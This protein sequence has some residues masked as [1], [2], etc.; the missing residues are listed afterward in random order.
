MLSGAHSASTRLPMQPPVERLAFLDGL[1]GWAALAVLLYYVFA[2]GFPPN[3]FAK[4]ELSKIVL[5]NGPYAVKLFFAISGVSLSLPYFA[6]PTAQT[7]VRLASGRYFRLAIPVFALCFLVQIAMLAGWPVPVDERPAVFREILNFD[8]TWGHLLGFGLFDVFLQYDKTQTYAGPLW[9]MQIEFTGSLFVLLLLFLLPSRRLRIG[10]CALL[11][12]ILS[13]IGSDMAFFVI[14]LLIAGHIGSLSAGGMRHLAPIAL[15]CGV[16][17]PILV[18]ALR[19]GGFMDG[20]CTMAAP[21]LLLIGVIGTPA[22]RGFLSNRVSRVLGHLSFPLYLIHCP[23]LFLLGIR[24]AVGQQGL[25]L[26]MVDCGLVLMSIL[27]AAA[28]APVNG[29]GIAISRRVGRVASARFA[30][31]PS[32]ISRPAQ[33]R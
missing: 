19:L 28:F 21:V 7:F 2:Q 1:R 20:F 10:A 30:I 22:M 8:P 16:V 13:A 6:R 12:A 25:G 15:F 4:S 31:D 18:P 23:I 14:G 9:T 3:A 5:F 29:L 24:M 27:A 11:A 17:G 32:S 26:F 33:K